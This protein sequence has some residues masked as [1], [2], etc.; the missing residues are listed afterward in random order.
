MSLSSYINAHE[1]LGELEKVV[2]TQAGN[3]VKLQH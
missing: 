2:E 3:T 1:N